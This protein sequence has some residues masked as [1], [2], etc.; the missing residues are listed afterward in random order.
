[1]RFLLIFIFVVSLSAEKVL[2][3]NSNSGVQKYNNVIETF[4][5]TFSYPHTILDISTMSSKEIKEYLY[6]NY[7]DLVYCVGNKAYQYAY[8]YLPEKKIFFSSVVNWKRLPATQKLYGISNELHGGVELTLITT[9]FKD[10][11]KIGIVYSKYT[12]DLY[13]NL[14]KYA[15]KMGIKLIA[16]QIN[17]PTDVDFK[18]LLDQTDAFL[19]IPDPVLLSSKNDVEKLFRVSKHLKKPIFAYDELFI[20]YGAVLVISVDTPTIGRQA[21]V[22]MENIIADKKIKKIQYPIGTSII[23]NKKVAQEMGIKYDLNSLSIVN[24][25]VE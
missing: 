1:M 10:V 5:D 14:H 2:I 25:I 13:E 21:A 19:I 20:Q 4:Q 16:K 8:K 6:D 15:L 18:K 7:P 24:E 23:F 11:K 17:K 3:I 9:I 12:Q 22:M